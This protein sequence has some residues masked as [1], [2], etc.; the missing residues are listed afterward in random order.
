MEADKNS[1]NDGKTVAATG[2]RM[3]FSGRTE[4]LDRRRLGKRPE[5]L[6]MRAK[7]PH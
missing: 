2:V 7:L 5:I 4:T 1:R 6:T 3:R